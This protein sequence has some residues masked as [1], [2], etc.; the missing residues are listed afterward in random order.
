MKILLGKLKGEAEDLASFLEEKLGVKVIRSGDSLGF[1]AG[2]RHD[3][4]TKG[5]LKTYLKRYLHLRGLKASYRPLVE[6]E[7]LRLSYLGEVEEE[8]KPAEATV[9]ESQRAQKPS[10][11]AIAA[12]E[13][14]A[15][16]EEP[17]ERKRRKTE[18]TKP[19]QPPRPHGRG[20]PSVGVT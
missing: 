16:G 5:L 2:S 3:S 6:G 1:E 12:D 15:S 10:E 9:T 11:E 14:K 18:K 19:G 8:E 20:L 4:F 17:K 7:E 13:K